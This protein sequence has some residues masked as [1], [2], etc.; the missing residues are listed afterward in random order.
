MWTHILEIG[1]KLI[2]NIE[3][4]QQNKAKFNANI[5]GFISEKSNK[6]FN[7]SY[8]A[9]NWEPCMQ[10]CNYSMGARTLTNQN[11]DTIKYSLRSKNSYD[12][13]NR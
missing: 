7:L 4:P 2:K 3:K 8:I 13:L 6:N 12:Q 1:M 5:P 9:T 11:T 10:G